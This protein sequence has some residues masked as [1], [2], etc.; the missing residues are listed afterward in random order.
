M[1]RLSELLYCTL[2]E[3]GCHKGY[4]LAADLSLR[5]LSELE[6]A[7]LKLVSFPNE[8]GMI[9]CADIDGHF[10]GISVLFCTDGYSITKL[11][12][13]LLA[14]RL[15]YSPV[16]VIVVGH[17]PPKD[18]Q[19]LLN[20]H[21]QTT[22]LEA[23]MHATGLTCISLS[24]LRNLQ[25]FV[26][27]I[28]EPQRQ[29]Q[30]VVLSITTADVIECRWESKKDLKRLLQH[31]VRQETSSTSVILEELLVKDTNVLII[32]GNG[33]N[34]HRSRLNQRVLRSE[35]KNQYLILPSAKGCVNENDP[36]CKGVYLGDFS[37]RPVCKALEV[38]ESFLLVEVEEH[39]M[40]ASLWKPFTAC[41]KWSLNKELVL[42]GKKVFTMSEP[43]GLDIDNQRVRPINWLD[44]LFCAT[45]SQSYP[46]RQN[47][48]ELPT[49]LKSLDRYEQL[50]HGLNA[51]ERP[52]MV[53]VDVGISCL[54]LFE[55]I[56]SPTQKFLANA[57]WANMGFCFAAGVAASAIWTENEL[58]IICGDGA[59]VMAMQDLLVF[60]REDISVRVVILDNKGYLTEE[61][62][63]SGSFNEGY[64][65]D[66][67]H[68]ARS[69]GFDHYA[70]VAEDQELLPELQMFA[71]TNTKQSLLWVEI[72][73][74]EAPQK[75]REQQVWNRIRK[76]MQ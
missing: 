69:I 3:L 64:T 42:T 2:K 58:W 5:L 19:S 45:E 30:P 68:F 71:T 10:S 61:L 59:A 22:R 29:Q 75:V 44:T 54:S 14:A 25:G 50:V 24:S 57:V 32:F 9:S 18:N 40:S 72:S 1:Y 74:A 62:K 27:A 34:R 16:L 11:I 6:Q 36:R 49:N 23:L 21:P 20:Y 31:N 43:N 8:E 67:C 41:E 48:I 28:L 4:T 12:N 53:I 13:G 65:V 46:K 7:G 51:I 17:A 56:V 39:E 33:I 66:W 38:A 73:P 26:D 70:K 35:F 60:V 55:C 37:S 47:P 63:Y 76:Q 52:R 15:R